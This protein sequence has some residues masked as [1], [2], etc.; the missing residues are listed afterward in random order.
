[1]LDKVGRSGEALPTRVTLMG[2]LARVDFLVFHEAAV[3]PEAP[4]THAALVRPG[5]LQVCPR[6]SPA[7]LALPGLPRARVRDSFAPVDPL[8]PQEMGIPPEGFATQ[9]APIWLLPRVDS[10]VFKEAAA[11][12]ESLATVNALIG[13][14]PSVDPLV[15]DEV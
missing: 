1:M 7:P 14:L 9:A 2:L 15:L 4:L 13:P 8:V 11:L 12:A 10:V 5:R 3:L 6:A